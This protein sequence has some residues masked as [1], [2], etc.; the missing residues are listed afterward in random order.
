MLRFAVALVVVVVLAGAEIAA[1]A[2]LGVAP[3]EVERFARQGSQP[4]P[5]GQGE[6]GSGQ[7]IPDPTA[8]WHLAREP[9]GPEDHVRVL[10]PQF[11]G[12]SLPPSHEA[13]CDCLP[14]M[15]P[16]PL[17][18]IWATGCL[19]PGSSPSASDYGAW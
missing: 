10:R 9:T 2:E 14:A 5:G 16:R 3:A 17:P 15:P 4:A 1:V 8:Q 11:G 6:E 12:D 18:A 13:N 19:A 7:A